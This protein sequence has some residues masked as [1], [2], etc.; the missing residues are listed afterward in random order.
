ME[1]VYLDTNIDDTPPALV[2]WISVP[3]GV[4]SA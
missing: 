3:S 2:K 4:S 1:D